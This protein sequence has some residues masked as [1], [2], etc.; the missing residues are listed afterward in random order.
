[1]RPRFGIN[2]TECAGGWFNG[3]HVD[4]WLFDFTVYVHPKW[5][6]L[7]FGRYRPKHSGTGDNGRPVGWLWQ[8]WACVPFV[9]VYVGWRLGGYYYRAGERRGKV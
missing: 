8:W 9:G 6:W 5:N 4:L 1:M 2:L 7:E 3:V